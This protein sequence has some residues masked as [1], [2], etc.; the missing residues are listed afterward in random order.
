MKNYIPSNDFFIEK[1]KYNFTITIQ[2]IYIY[3]YIYIERERER[4]REILARCTSLIL[5]GCF[6]KFEVFFFFWYRDHLPRLCRIVD[7]SFCSFRVEGP[8]VYKKIE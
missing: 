2:N 4:E 6:Y 8:Y 1:Q 3:I 7:T 5:P